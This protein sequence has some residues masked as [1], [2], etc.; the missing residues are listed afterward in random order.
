METRTGEEM[1]AEEI[2]KETIKFELEEAD[3]NISDLLA[4]E[5]QKKN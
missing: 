3:S 1:T 4:R 5:R 2:R